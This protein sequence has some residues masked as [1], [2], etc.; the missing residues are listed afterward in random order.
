VDVPGCLSIEA[1]GK[2]ATAKK[3]CYL[4]DFQTRTDP[5]YQE[6][7]ARVGRVA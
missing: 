4:V 6:A 3:L 7:I 1:D 5:F 2:K